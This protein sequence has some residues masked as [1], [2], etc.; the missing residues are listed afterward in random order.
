MARSMT[1]SC[2][3]MESS[4]YDQVR[5]QIPLHL[6]ATFSGRLTTVSR[7]LESLKIKCFIFHQRAYIIRFEHMILLITNAIYV[8]LLYTL[9]HA[10]GRLYITNKIVTGT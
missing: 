1:A 6:T 5:A 8:K 10:H 9:G 3:M 7:R 2:S 4:R